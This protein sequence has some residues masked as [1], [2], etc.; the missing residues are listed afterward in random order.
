MGAQLQVLEQ[1]QSQQHTETEALTLWYLDFCGELDLGNQSSGIVQESVELKDNSATYVG[2]G[3]GQ[4]QGHLPII[5]ARISRKH[6]E[7][8]IT[9]M[10]IQVKDL[11]STN[12]TSINGVPVT[13]EPLS[14]I[15]TVGDVITFDHLNFRVRRSMNLPEATTDLAPR[16]SKKRSNPLSA[17][18]ARQRLMQ[19]RDALNASSGNI[20]S[21]SFASNYSE[22]KKTPSKYINI[23]DSKIPVLSSR[24]QD[25]RPIV[26]GISA[27]V[28]LFV[29]FI[30]TLT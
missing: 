25:F 22:D 8:N 15:A 24:Y 1:Q 30:V 10:G 3:V 19:A 6:A 21:A 28:A 4:G 16:P 29:F 26:Y 17:G 18:L 5:N 20:D 27:G 23:K 9:S 13:D 11:G 12:G 7:L 2:R 14:Q